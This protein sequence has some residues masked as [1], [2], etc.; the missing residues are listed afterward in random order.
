[1]QN[2]KPNPRHFAACLA[3]R[4]QAHTAFEKAKATL[5]EAESLYAHACHHQQLRD[6]QEL[7]E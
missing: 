5:A 4:V 6:L 3:F 2:S 7:C 1:M